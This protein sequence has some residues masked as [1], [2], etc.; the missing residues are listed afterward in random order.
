MHC[1]YLLAR[2]AKMK[3]TDIIRCWQGCRV[4]RTALVK[5]GKTIEETGIIY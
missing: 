5:T 3:R 1:Y 2:M 4:A